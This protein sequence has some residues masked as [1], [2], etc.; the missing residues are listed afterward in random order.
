[1]KGKAIIGGLVLSGIL[2]VVPSL[3]NVSVKAEKSDKADQCFEEFIETDAN[4]QVTYESKPLYNE[5]LEESGRQYDF[6]IE[7]KTGYALLAEIGGTDEKLYEI[8]ELFYDATSP[9]DACMG[10]PVYI[11]HRLYLDYIEGEFYNLSDGEKVEAEAVEQATYE[12]FGYGGGDYFQPQVQTIDYA[13][14]AETGNYSI[15]YD[16]P[17]YY[18]KAGE[19]SCANTAGAVLI[20]Y[21]DRFYENLIPDY[22]VYRTLGTSFSYKATSQEIINLTA[23]L[24]TLMSTDV[25]KQG[26]TYAE[27]QDG[28]Q[29]YI[30]GKGYTYTTTSVFSWGKFSFDKYKQSVESGKPVA[31][32][33]SGFAFRVGIEE[34]T[35]R[36]VIHNDYCALTHVA[37]GCGY[38]Q[39]TYYDSNNRE[40]AA[41]T[42][43]KVSSGLSGYDIGYLNITGIGNIDKA[44]SVEIK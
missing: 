9:F 38:K 21:Y 39:D 11:T 19:T 31:L 6:T 4:G 33:L 16:L 5:K 13:R 40:I 7:G 10:K 22:K 27:F 35:G 36:D 17:N 44:I 23:E 14:K 24:H 32:F 15:Q 26:T 12:G 41:K 25:G 8:E 42:Y 30:S 20:G 3:G 2:G 28:M 29:K 34:S 1:M 18:G 43:L 37:V